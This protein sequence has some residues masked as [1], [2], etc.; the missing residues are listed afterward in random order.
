MFL[1]W[2]FHFSVCNRVSR[3][4]CLKI[5]NTVRP[6]KYNSINSRPF[7]FVVTVLLLVG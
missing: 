1:H 2:V 7:I 6:K 4:R 5:Q 3:M